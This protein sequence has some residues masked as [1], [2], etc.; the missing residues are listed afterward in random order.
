MQNDHDRAY[1]V[2]IVLTND[3]DDAV[4]ESAFSVQPEEGQGIGDDYPAGTYSLAVSLADRA[5]LRSYWNTERCEV[6]QVR[7]EIGNDGHVTN[8]VRCANR[9]TTTT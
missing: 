2:R 6:L 3:N 1:D 8:T 9:T 4:L 7:V 5:M